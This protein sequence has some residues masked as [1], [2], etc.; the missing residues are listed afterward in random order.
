M[1][2]ADY[3]LLRMVCSSTMLGAWVH[4]SYGNH[5]SPIRS[6]LRHKDGLVL[7]HL[8]SGFL[9]RANAIVL[10]L[11]S[12]A[13]AGRLATVDIPG[14][15]LVNVHPAHLVLRTQAHFIT[16]LDRPQIEPSLM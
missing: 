6:T 9:Y 2:V 11:C 16:A 10:A 13:M 8:L 4:P 12:S 14:Y 7:C 3:I 1:T 5:P 15:E